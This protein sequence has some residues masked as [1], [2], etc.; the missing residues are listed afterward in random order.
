M[1]SLFAIYYDA[2]R[3]SHDRR[4]S[5]GRQAKASKLEA[6]IRMICRRYGEI[7]D[8]AACATAG[9]LHTRQ[10]LGGSQSLVQNRAIGLPGRTRLASNSTKRFTQ[11]ASIRSLHDRTETHQDAVRVIAL[12]VD[13]RSSN[14][15]VATRKTEATEETESKSSVTSVCSVGS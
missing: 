14:S 12:Q 11:T 3:F 8:N 6:R 1:E 15:C 4:L 9:T 13:D 2:V 5:A 7:L 10:C